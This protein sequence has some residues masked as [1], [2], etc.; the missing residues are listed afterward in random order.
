[1]TVHI[2]LNPSI[3][4]KLRNELKAARPDVSAPLSMKDTEQLPYLSAV[5]AEGLRLAVGTSQRQTRINPNDVMVFND[6]K[7]SWKIPPGVITIPPLFPIP[8]LHGLTDT[9]D[10]RRHVR[11]PRPSFPR[12]I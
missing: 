3:L 11:A 7:K 5:V 1:M 10:T 6:G 4:A 12:Y 2:L 9:P 8:H